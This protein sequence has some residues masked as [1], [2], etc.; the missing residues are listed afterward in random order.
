MSKI[1]EELKAATGL[2][3]KKKESRQKWLRRL[4]E[5]VQDL[6]DDTWETLSHPAQTWTNE[7]A[8]NIGADKDVEEFPDLEDDAPPTDKKKSKSKSKSKDDGEGKQTG[9]TTAIKDIMLKDMKISA[10]DLMTELEKRG[11]SKLSRFTV[12]T[13]RSDF[14]NSVRMM[15]ER[16]IDPQEIEL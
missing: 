8:T 9:I 4:N 14:R 1:E 2:E 16:K 13:I 12:T 3:R 15:K 5:A 6:P 10:A 11:H 7:G